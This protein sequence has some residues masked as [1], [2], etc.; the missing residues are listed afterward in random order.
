MFKNM[1][2]ATKLSIVLGSVLAAIL[3]VLVVSSAF[4]ASTSIGQGVSGELSA[5]AKSNAQQIQQIFNEADFA[6]SSMNNYLESAYQRGQSNP[7]ENVVSSNPDIAALCQSSIYNTA[8]SS[9]GYDAE[10][11]MVE[12]A[13]NTVKNNVGIEGVGVMFEPYKFETA[14]RDYAFY[15]STETADSLVRPYGSYEEYSTEEWYSE[16]VKSQKEIVTEPYEYDGK[17]LLSYAHPLVINGEVQGVTFADVAVDTFSS[18]NTTNDNFKTMWVTIYNAAGNIIWDSETLNDVGRNVSEFTPKQDELQQ[19][20]NGMAGTTA[21]NLDKTREDGK[22]TSC[23]YSPIQVG[24]QVWWSMTGV[25]SADAEKSVVQSVTML[26]ILSGVALLLV[27]FTTVFLL[28]RMLKP[29]GKIVQAAD[30]IVAGN[31]DI[32]L[33]TK[34]GDEI[35]KLAHAFRTMSRNLKDIISDINYVLSEMAN[36]NFQVHTR[37]EEHYVGAYQGV[38][39]AIRLIN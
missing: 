27:V 14:M 23:F 25:Y 18:M 31:L 5:I 3:V 2:L 36:G 21:F 11:F 19:V 28:R 10:N 1:N 30:E 34:S 6:A 17:L 35:G 22:K 39:M 38:L 37:S 33:D 7:E 8:L 15:I 12:T 16:A 4:M 29:V 24:D 20:M 13:R 26:L 32:Q 9:V